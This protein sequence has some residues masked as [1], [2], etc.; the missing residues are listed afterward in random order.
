MALTTATISG[1]FVRPDAGAA[2]ITAYIEAASANSMLTAS[3]S[4]ILSKVP[5]KIQSDGTASVTIWQLP[6]AGILPSDARWRLVMLVG[7]NRYTKEFNLT[8]D[9]TWNTLVDVSGVPITSSLVSQAQAAAAA[10][11]ASAA[12]ISGV[13]AV[14][15]TG[16]TSVKNPTYGAVG[17][18]IADDTTAI[19]AA[20]DA[21]GVG[22]T[23]VFPAGTYK[24][25]GLTASLANQLWV[26]LPGATIHATGANHAISV[27]ANGVTIQGP[28]KV[29][30]GAASAFS[31]VFIGAGLADVDVLGVEITNG[32]NG[33][34]CK[35]V[36][37]T[38]TVR[39]RVSGCTIH[40]VSGNGV[41]FNWQ[42]TDSQVTNNQ[43]YSC[44]GNGVWA[45]EDS[46]RLV[47][48]DNN[49]KDCTAQGIGFNGTSGLTGAPDS[50]VSGNVIVNSGSMGVSIDSSDGCE[51]S[52][53]TIFTSGSYGVEL[54]GS[55]RCVVDGNVIDGASYGV[56][57]SALSFTCHDSVVSN[58]T[59]RNTV[60]QGIYNGG[61][62]GTGGKR[63]IVTGNKIID[64][65]PTGGI[66][67][68]ACAFNI[69]AND[70]LVADN[71]IY[72]TTA[73]SSIASASFINANGSGW[74]IQDNYVYIEAAITTGGGT[75][76]NLSSVALN[77]TVLNNTV[78]GNGKLGRGVLL[79]AACTGCMV[80]G[81]RIMGTAT[82]A[83][84]GT[85][86]D[87][88]NT[89]VANVI[90][91]SAGN[92]YIHGS[93]SHALN[94]TTTLATFDITGA[95]GTTAPAAGGAGALP[96]TPLGYLTVNINGT[97]RQIAYY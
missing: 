35:G 1:T 83:I 80:S 73:I 85:T 88:T 51:V 21:A 8:G 68:I 23:V 92:G 76:I 60:N 61:G 49:I 41:F 43:I 79:N 53:N 70:W 97:N 46:F 66:N 34:R 57:I 9:I 74:T 18:D 7:Q 67:A 19:H 22:G 28:G 36:T 39:V 75:A 58:N 3:G 71:H 63:L 55:A 62:A 82:A 15:W 12:S 93:A 33:V 31:G 50:V 56:S 78:S 30:T 89:I 69:G 27:T 13:T 91:P 95:S 17:N 44:G 47:V 84:D 52:S 40:G 20:R 32:A 54:A 94:R 37:G 42:T 90:T 72:I 5:I 24:T 38:V 10:A 6:Q 87:S 29:D 86:I 4:V 96:A 59:I 81:N 2:L 26:L 45:G 11:A 64:P 65:G 14:T 77:T 48:S 16:Q 25:T